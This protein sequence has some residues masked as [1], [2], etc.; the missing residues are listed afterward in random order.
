MCLCVYIVPSCVLLCKSRFDGVFIWSDM[1]HGEKMDHSIQ[2]VGGLEHFVFSIYGMS[3]QPHW[4]SLHHFSWLKRS[5]NQTA[6]AR[7]SRLDRPGTSLDIWLVVWNC[8]KHDFYNFP[9]GWSSKDWRIFWSLNIGWYWE[10]CICSHHIGKNHHP[11][12]RS[13]EGLVETTNQT[14]YVQNPLSFIK[15][16]SSAIM[17]IIDYHGLLDSCWFPSSHHSP[18]SEK[19]SW[20]ARQD[21]YERVLPTGMLRGSQGQWND[22]GKGH[23]GRWRLTQATTDV[24]HV[25]C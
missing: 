8:G 18:I 10:Y 2:L 19:T 17:M 7:H 16:S 3:S 23:V 20:S 12:W 25:N 6:I 4:L 9:Y 21:F 22:V 14:W 11:N 24:G 1:C 15:S 13:P 5:T